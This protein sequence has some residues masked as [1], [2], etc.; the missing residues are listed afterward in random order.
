LARSVTIS[1]CAK[2]ISTGTLT[3]EHTFTQM[4]IHRIVT[5]KTTRP[6]IFPV[7]VSV[8]QHCKSV[9]LYVVLVGLLGRVYGI[10]DTRQRS[11]SHGYPNIRRVKLNFAFGASYSN[12][13]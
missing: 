2:A 10:G 7:P 13:R 6:H 5:V 12:G 1:I 3:F 8:G 9:V 4:K 11:D